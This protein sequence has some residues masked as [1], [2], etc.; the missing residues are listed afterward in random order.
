[1]TVPAFG[2]GVAEVA[3]PLGPAIHWDIEDVN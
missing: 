2:A 3:I 1:V